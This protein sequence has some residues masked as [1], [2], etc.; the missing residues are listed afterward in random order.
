MVYIYTMEF[1][2]A[3]K[4]NNFFVKMNGTEKRF[5]GTLNP[6]LEIDII[7]SL[8][9]ADLSFKILNFYA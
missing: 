6:H 3:L 9:Y 7:D 5:M 2:A 1:H 8:S 4:G